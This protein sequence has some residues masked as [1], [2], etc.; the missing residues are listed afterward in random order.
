[1][2][3]NIA[4]LP[5]DFGKTTI[6]DCRVNQFVAIVWLGGR[7]ND[8]YDAAGVDQ[9]VAMSGA[10]A[11]RRL[12]AVDLQASDDFGRS[13]SYL[14]GAVSNIL[15]I[16]GS[17]LYRRAFDIGLSEWRSM[18]VLAIE[19]RISAR[20]ASQIMGLD[21]AAVSRAV[22]ALERAGLVR[23][24]LDPSDSRQRIIELSEAGAELHSRIIIV[25]KERERRLLSPFTKDEVRVLAGLLRRMHAHAANVNAFDPHTFFESAGS[26]TGAAPRRPRRPARR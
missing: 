25:A 15:S 26:S 1:L 10:P 20:R 11:A 12:K 14:I 2:R 5:L 17:R 9:E 22:A 13:I 21:K 3:R 7:C 4:I 23:I 19:P 18:W 6:F 16:G 24:A 8:A